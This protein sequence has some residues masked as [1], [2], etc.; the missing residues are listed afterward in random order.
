MVVV[1]ERWKTCKVFHIFNTRSSVLPFFSV[2]DGGTRGGTTTPPLVVVG[3]WSKSGFFRS[4]A[5]LFFA[6]VHH[7]FTSFLCKRY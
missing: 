3:H 6:F 2:G 1:L 4:L 5:F 7:L